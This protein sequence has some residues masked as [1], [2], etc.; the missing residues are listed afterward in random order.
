MQNIM[1]CF[2]QII[3]LAAQNSMGCFRDLN[4]RLFIELWHPIEELLKPKAAKLVSLRSNSCSASSLVSTT[5]IFLQPE[6]FPP[7]SV[8]EK[9]RFGKKWTELHFRRK[10]FF[11]VLRFLEQF[12]KRDVLRSFDSLHLCCCC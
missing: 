10:T 11:V 1:F 2:R 9:F 7:V 8:S 12:G 5:F 6:F 3:F 4:Y